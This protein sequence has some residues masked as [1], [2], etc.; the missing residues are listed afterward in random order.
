ME[1][2]KMISPR[3]TGLRPSSFKDFLDHKRVAVPLVK[4]LPLLSV[5]RLCLICFIYV[6]TLQTPRLLFLRFLFHI[7]MELT[8]QV[9]TKIFS[10]AS[11]RWGRLRAG[12]L[13][14]NGPETWG[15][16]N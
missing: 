8:T 15:T 1:I 5:T 14:A 7:N 3:E 2:E 12:R 11:D 16:I 6:A 13:M 9:Q 4:N 10:S